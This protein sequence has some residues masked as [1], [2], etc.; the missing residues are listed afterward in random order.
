MNFI[1]PDRGLKL[2]LMCRN[3]YRYDW[4]PFSPTSPQALQQQQSFLFRNIKLTHHGE[5][6]CLALDPVV[7]FAVKEN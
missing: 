5:S 6:L 1:V 3:T 7:L 4:K 2:C